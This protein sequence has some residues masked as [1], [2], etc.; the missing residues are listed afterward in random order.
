MKFHPYGNVLATG[1]SDNSIKLWDIRNNQL[2]QH[3]SAHDL[4]VSCIDFHPSGNYL[5]SSSL[6]SSIRLWD[7]RKGHQ[8]YTIHGHPSAVNACAFTADGRS[9][10][11]G[12]D[13][14]RVITWNS[15]LEP[16][17][18]KASRGVGGVAFAALPRVGTTEDPSASKRPQR[19]ALL[20][21]QVAR[22]VQSNTGVLGRNNIVQGR[23]DAHYESE[24]LG[25]AFVR[26]EPSGPLPPT[27]LP[28]S[29]PPRLV[30][31][32]ERIAPPNYTFRTGPDAG[33]VIGPGSLF[34]GDPDE[35]QPLASPSAP[36]ETTE[37]DTPQPCDYRHTHLQ[38][39]TGAIHSFG[40]VHD[41]ELAAR[42]RA[43]RDARA[44]AVAAGEVREE[45]LEDQPLE[46][47]L[48]GFAIPGVHGPTE[49][50]RAST[51][52]G[53]P[54]PSRLASPRQQGDEP[55]HTARSTGPP[56]FAASAAGLQASSV[57]AS[58]SRGRDG[59][60][61]PA[62]TGRNNDD[63]VYS[64]QSDRFVPASSHAHQA[65]TAEV[66][67][68]RNTPGVD[69]FAI[70]PADHIQRLPEQLA[71]T[72]K[73]MVNQLDQVTRV[74]HAHAKHTESACAQARSPSAPV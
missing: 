24:G 53:L 67:A 12:G 60:V 25:S 38:T 27:D 26:P 66:A 21:S 65:Q 29:L 42:A 61:A 1:C 13:D 46:E 52:S 32:R 14:Q 35:R 16:E 33:T 55:P 43:I 49:T 20:A 36:E 39:T 6:D 54:G 63:F 15:H 57:Q 71:H 11:T 8:L 48:A 62:P 22:P 34:L 28:R 44:A 30:G 3:Y 72:L 58:V 5:L 45:A 10:V 56:S 51:R 17:L 19:G 69:I 4:D 74:R 47:Q 41:P 23:R 2:L 70:P 7:L 50:G 64:F 9:F 37:N 73:Y 59:A 31:G 18:D 40:D 68:L